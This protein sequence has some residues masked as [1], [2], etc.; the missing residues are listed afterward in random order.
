[1]PC[2]NI[3]TTMLGQ[4]ATIGEKWTLSS[5]ILRR[6]N[7]VCFIS[8]LRAEHGVDTLVCKHQGAHTHP[9][10]LDNAL[11]QGY[12][13]LLRAAI[14]GGMVDSYVEKFLLQDGIN[15]KQVPTESLSKLKRYL[16]KFSKL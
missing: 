13:L 12:K 5:S 9:L 1:M 8:E 16:E 15:V 10:N 11:F 2:I 14:S 6:D 7:F 4:V 3:L